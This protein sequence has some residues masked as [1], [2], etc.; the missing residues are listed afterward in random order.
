MIE[1]SPSQESRTLALL[2]SRGQSWIPAPE[3]AKISL[4]YCRV[5]ACLR[6]KGFRI[7]NRVETRNGIKYGFYRLSDEKPISAKPGTPPGLFPAVELERTARW[8][9]NG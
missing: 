2:K 3:L 4:Q 1:R 6:K 9:D 5:I 7:Q 8:E